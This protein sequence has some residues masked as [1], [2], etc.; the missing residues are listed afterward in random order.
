MTHFYV[1]REELY[2]AVWTTPIL[3]LAP[4]LGLSD[5]GLAKLC[6]R[7]EIPVPGL[8]YWRKVELGQIVKK[9]RLPKPSEKCYLY[10][11]FWEPGFVE[12]QKKKKLEDAPLVLEVKELVNQPE[13]R[14][15]VPEDITTYHPLIKS[16]LKSLRASWA[17][18]YGICRPFDEEALDVYCAKASFPRMA[19]LFHVLIT[20]L[21]KRGHTIYVNQKLT[22]PLFYK[23]SNEGTRIDYYGEVI[24]ISLVE[25]VDRVDH[26]RTSREEKYNSGP[27]Y[28]FIPNGKFSLIVE[29]ASTCD[30][31]RRWSDKKNKPLET[32]LNDIFIDLAKIAVHLRLKREKKEA[33]EREDERKRQEAELRRQ[34][35]LE[36]E[37][38]I[39]QLENFFTQWLK[40]KQIREFLSLAEKSSIKPETLDMSQEEWLVWA[41][42]YADQLDPFLRSSSHSL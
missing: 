12:E 9:S 1:S 34:K 28:D 18:K 13:N 19:R 17:S 6:A 4:E 26:K 23:R 10:T 42:N 7:M 36:E 38:R 2:E 35:Q 3:R 41:R 39:Q 11:R 8:G 24:R 22:K 31:K 33:D 21:E 27:K 32:Q 37:K 16:T 14:I 30:T 20:S 25:K 15:I 29:N 5:R 40:A